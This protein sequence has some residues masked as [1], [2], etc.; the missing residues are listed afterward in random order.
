MG[1]PPH[2]L[3]WTGD[4]SDVHI[5][6][7]LWLLNRALVN[8]GPYRAC[9]K[10]PSPAHSHALAKYFTAVAWQEKL[11]EAMLAAYLWLFSA[12]TVYRKRGVEA[13][14]LSLPQ[15]EPFRKWLENV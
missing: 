10:S 7:P 4:L 12:P 1:S 2:E 3:P 14:M 5:S 6:F 11:L 9:A 8:K 13:Y 15:T